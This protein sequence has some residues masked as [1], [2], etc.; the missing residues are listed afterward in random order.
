MNMCAIQMSA[1]AV[2]AGSIGNVLGANISQGKVNEC[3][4]LQ[5]STAMPTLRGEA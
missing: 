3:T 5:L 1:T 4:K 2:I